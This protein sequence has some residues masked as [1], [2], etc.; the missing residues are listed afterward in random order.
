MERNMSKNREKAPEE[1]R[2]KKS[3]RPN[4]LMIMADEFRFPIHKDAGGMPKDLKNILGF[5]NVDNEDG[6][7][8]SEEAKALFPGFMRLRENTVVL[9]NH[10]IAQTACVPSRAALFTG[11]FGNKTGVTQ[12]D[13]VFKKASEIKW[14]APKSIPTL[15]DW[16]KSNAYST[17][18]FGKCH[19]AHPEDYSLKDWGF[20]DWEASFPE[21]HGSL[22]NNLGLYRDPGFTDLVTTFLRRKGMALDYDREVGKIDMD[23]SLNDDERKAAIDAIEIPPWFAVASFTNPHDITTW[24]ILTGKA[25]GINFLEEARATDPLPIPDTEQMSAKPDN[26]TWRFR[27]NPGGFDNTGFTLPNSASEDLH[28]NNKPA[29]QFDYSLKLGIAVAS[30]SGNAAFASRSPNLT[31]LPLALAPRPLDW[32][33]AYLDYYAYLQYMLDQQIDRI[34]KT[35]DEAGL[36]EN[37]IVVFIPDHGEYGGSHGMMQQKWHSAYQEAIHVP[38]IVR[39]PTPAKKD[40]GDVETP[41]STPTPTPRQITALTSHLDIAPTLL[42]LVG[43][44]EKELQELAAT[45]DGKALEFVGADLTGLI[46]KGE[47]TI[48]DRFGPKG[49][50]NREA[51]LFTTSDMIT[52]PKD[53]SEKPSGDYASFLE[54]VETQMT[55]PRKCGLDDNQ[56]TTAAKMNPGAIVQPAEVHCVREGSW[57]LVR[58]RNFHDKEDA[59]QFQWEMYNLDTDPA[60]MKNLLLFNRERFVANPAIP[61]DLNGMDAKAIAKKANHLYEVMLD[62]IANMIGE[63]VNQE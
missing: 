1:N 60:E 13:G 62:L 18:Y 5:Q 49:R 9:S 19:F 33:K 21:P 7:Y 24:P 61:E 26:G 22:V 29:C 56:A 37:T 30:L 32:T 17:H 6:D 4:V 10:T 47:T 27:M 50:G 14:L 11:Q 3:K 36:S 38:V 54:A 31:G 35:L 51:V 34:M 45:F 46:T 42:G 15:G 55:S 28:S 8:I 58:Y 25:Q 2:P 59:T 48:P 39:M 12:T 20:D 52:E 44:D 63:E 57:K 16:F 23:E 41:T 40:E 53:L 43:V